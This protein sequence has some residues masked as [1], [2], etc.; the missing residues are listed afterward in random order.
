MAKLTPAQAEARK[1]KA[2]E[3]RAAKNDYREWAK[4]DLVVQAKTL[5]ITGASSAPKEVLIT[6]IVNA[7]QVDSGRRKG[8]KKLTAAEKAAVREEQRAM[9]L[10]Q[11]DWKGRGPFRLIVMLNGVQYAEMG[12]YASARGAQ[13]DAKTLLRRMA[14]VQF[15]MIRH[16]VR[17]DDTDGGDD[18]EESLNEGPEFGFPFAGGTAE[19]GWYTAPKKAAENLPGTIEAD[20]FVV[21]MPKDGK[22]AY[23]KAKIPEV[24]RNNG[25]RRKKASTGRL[26]WAAGR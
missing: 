19:D 1:A 14:P 6:A 23:D 10:A 21:K 13:S 26:F 3:T 2:A 20:A 9:K 18:E 7:E 12:P 4:Q 17:P 15:Y 24:L 16:G 25:A 22:K 5:G 8:K 11:R